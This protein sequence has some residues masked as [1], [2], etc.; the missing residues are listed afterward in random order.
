MTPRPALILPA[1][2]AALCW[3]AASP[4]AAAGEPPLADPTRPAGRVSPVRAP[5]PSRS[6]APATA[7]SAAASL[8]P[9]L[10]ALQIATIAG[11]SAL[12]DGRVL[13]VG[14][15]LGELTVTAI[16][17]HGV[18]LRGPQIEQRLALLPG[19][20]AKVASRTPAGRDVYPAV[21]LAP[22]ETR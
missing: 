15:R 22:K 8:A 13:H 16:D 21:A 6:A 5:A 3:L 20:G 14:D 4:I 9:R 7:A 2:A 19:V 1:A 18:L 17:A 11:S 10:Q 12:V